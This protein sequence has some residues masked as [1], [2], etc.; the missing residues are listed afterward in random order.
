MLKVC[1]NEVSESFAQKHVLNTG[2]R[3]LRYLFTCMR[4]ARTI[5]PT[6]I[7]K[8]MRTTLCYGRLL[9]SGD[10]YARLIELTNVQTG[11]A[12]MFRN[13]VVASPVK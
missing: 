2:P 4:A 12:T 13:H 6:A 11:D 1:L 5:F 9:L 3:M 10:R 8:Y 7:K